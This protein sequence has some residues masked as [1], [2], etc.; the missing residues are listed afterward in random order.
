MNINL[1]TKRL[2]IKPI[3]ENYIENVYHLQCLEETA[4]Y[5]TSS[6]PNSINDTKI[7]VEKWISENNKEKVTQFTF[8]V[9]LIGENKFIGLIGVRL[10]KEH[11]KNAEVWFQYDY[12]FWNKGYATECL[13]KIIE[14]GFEQLKLH[15]IEAG[16]AFENIGSIRVL[17]KVGMQ[18]EAHTRKLLPLKSGWSDNYGYAIL[19]IDLRK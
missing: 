18:R 14:F 8:A 3:S 15:R 6:I 19:S 17:E 2:N 16:C 9:E 10:G 1:K 12:C 4:K 7:T 11:Y 5:N 13:R